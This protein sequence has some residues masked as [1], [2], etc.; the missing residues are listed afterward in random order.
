MKYIFIK[1]IIQR[2]KCCPK[3]IR[4]LPY[5]GV[6]K[7]II[8]VPLSSPPIS[9]P[10]SSHLPPCG[11]SRSGADDF[12]YQGNPALPQRCQPCPKSRDDSHSRVPRHQRPRPLTPMP[13]MLI[14]ALAMTSAPTL[15]KKKKTC[16]LSPRSRRRT[17]SI[18]NAKQTDS[19]YSPLLYYRCY[20]LLSEPNKTYI[21]ILMSHDAFLVNM[22]LIIMFF[23][24]VDLSHA[25][26]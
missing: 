15:A 22:L 6:A 20:A 18:H 25:K 10:L 2:Y 23:I 19:V 9:C 7:I 11:D 5:H 14:A 3:Q 16:P 1:K 8:V 12:H 13:K 26:L 17:G 21:V 24:N 4:Y